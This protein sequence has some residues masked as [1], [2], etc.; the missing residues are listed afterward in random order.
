[1]YKSNEIVNNICY[2]GLGSNLGNRLINIQ[3]AIS[4][5]KSN[6]KIRVIKIS[7]IKDT[8]PWGNKDQPDFLNCILEIE[9]SLDPIK[10]LKT[11]FIIETMVGRFRNE[12]WEPRIIDIDILF[13]GNEIVDEENLIIPHPLIHK[14]E[15]VLG[16]LNEICPDLV[17]PILKESITNIF[18]EF[19]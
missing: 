1:M 10:L 14:R 4:K 16:S 12:K 13:Y 17:H 15:F 9:T 11:C 19:A 5:L 18:K 7:S 3:K 2:L 8:K 6:D